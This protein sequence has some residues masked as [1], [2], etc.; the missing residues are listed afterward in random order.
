MLSGDRAVV[1]GELD[2]APVI[3]RCDGC[4]TWAQLVQRIDARHLRELTPAERAKYLR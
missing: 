4:G 1:T 2:G 3:R